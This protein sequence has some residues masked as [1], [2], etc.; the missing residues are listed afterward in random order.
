MPASLRSSVSLP[1]AP[2]AGLPGDS[3]GVSR[4]RG[5]G[6]YRRGGGPIGLGIYLE[7]DAWRIERA[8]LARR[9]LRITL[10]GR[11]DLVG[12]A[13]DLNQTLPPGASVAVCFFGDDAMRH[14]CRIASSISFTR[15]TSDQRRDIFWSSPS[16]KRPAGIRDDL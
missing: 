11:L 12:V 1:S 4:A 14:M 10:F 8:V 7:V 9:P 5:W 3:L 13:N 2:P 15:S 6:R 16:I